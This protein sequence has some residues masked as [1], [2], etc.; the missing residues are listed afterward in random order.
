MVFLVIQRADARTWA[1]A[2]VTRLNPTSG[3]CWFLV[4]GFGHRCVRS[5]VSELAQEPAQGK[6][7]VAG[8]EA[9]LDRRL[10]AFFGLRAAH[11]LSEKIGIATEILDRRQRDS[12]D[13]LFEIARQPYAVGSAEGPPEN[14]S[15]FARKG[16]HGESGGSFNGSDR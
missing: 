6:F 4:Y 15:A 13:P 2:T 11:A 3:G 1:A 5:T 16:P 9:A 12:I 7:G 8:L 10:D 14:H